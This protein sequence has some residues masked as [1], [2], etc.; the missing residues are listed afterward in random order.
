MVGSAGS[1]SV[2]G[3]HLTHPARSTAAARVAGDARGAVFQVG[4]P[5]KSSMTTE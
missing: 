4:D 3:F 5:R 2:L 1:M